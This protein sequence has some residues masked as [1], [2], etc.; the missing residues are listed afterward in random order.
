[1][2]AIR[3]LHFENEWMALQNSLF[4]YLG[5]PEGS[6]A[7]IIKMGPVA[8][9]ACADIPETYMIDRITMM[10]PPPNND[11][12]YGG[13]RANYRS[14][15]TGGTPNALEILVEGREGGVRRMNWRKR[16][17]ERGIFVVL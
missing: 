13:G 8:P 12:H 14:R 4:G 11:P 6:P 10:P 17:G 16:G 9:P 15:W 5:A 2:L 1:V 7:A 3:S